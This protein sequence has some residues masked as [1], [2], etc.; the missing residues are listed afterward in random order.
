VL[1]E[2]EHV[3]YESLSDDEIARIRAL[4]D[5][6]SRAPWR[7]MVEGRDHTSGP[8]F[9]MI[10]PPD[11]RQVDMYVTIDSDP[12]DAPDLD[13]I[14]AGRSYLPRLLDELSLKANEPLSDVEIARLRAVCEA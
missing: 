7:A 6:A 3:T 1:E 8:S 14:A 2:P 11:H 4:C 10:G 5:A 13:M 9:V 12:A